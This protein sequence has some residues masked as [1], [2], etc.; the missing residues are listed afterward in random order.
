MGCFP[1]IRPQYEHSSRCT[2]RTRVRTEASRR[3]SPAVEVKSIIS[4]EI[5]KTFSL[6][7]FS[8][9]LIGELEW[10]TIGS[11]SIKDQSAGT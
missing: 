7:E 8:L 3:R 9:V 4:I 11:A 10:P 2:E 5:L 1:V 6:R